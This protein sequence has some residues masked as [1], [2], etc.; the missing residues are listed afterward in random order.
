MR[1]KLAALA[2]FCVVG[3][4]I[5]F[6]KLCELAEQVVEGGSFASDP[7]S[8]QM[9]SGAGAVGFSAP[10]SEEVM[11]DKRL[12]VGFLRPVRPGFGR[13]AD[14]RAAAVLCAA[15]ATAYAEPAI[16]TAQRPRRTACAPATAA[17]KVCIGHT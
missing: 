4:E 14:E 15:I 6:R 16:T 8:M 9:L 11:T 12:Y 3:K 7:A 10:T 1:A 5:L 2:V 17:R 13:P